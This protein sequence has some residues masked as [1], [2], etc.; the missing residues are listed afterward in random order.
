MRFSLAFLLKTYEV[1]TSQSDPEPT[2]I[3]D[4][5]GWEPIS[6]FYRLWASLINEDMRHRSAS[7]ALQAASIDPICSDDD[8]KDIFK[9]RR[10]DRWIDDLK[11]TDLVAK[12]YELCEKYMGDDY[13]RRLSVMDLL[14][15]T[16]FRTRFDEYFKRQIRQL[17]S[18]SCQIKPTI[19]TSYGHAERHHITVDTKDSSGTR[20]T[21]LIVEKLAEEKLINLPEGGSAKSFCES[22][23]NE[24]TVISGMCPIDG[25]PKPFPSVSGDEYTKGFISAIRELYNPLIQEDCVLSRSV[26]QIFKDAQRL[27]GA[28]LAQRIAAEEFRSSAV[29]SRGKAAE[30]EVEKFIEIKRGENEWR[31][32]DLATSQFNYEYQ[33]IWDVCTEASAVYSFVGRGLK[34]NEFNG[35]G[36]QIPGDDQSWKRFNYTSD[37][38]PKP[39]EYYQ[40]ITDDCAYLM[41]LMRVP[42]TIDSPIAK[43]PTK[44]EMYNMIATFVEDVNDMPLGSPDALDHY[45]EYVWRYLTEGIHRKYWQTDEGEFSRSIQIDCMACSGSATL[46][47]FITAS[48]LSHGFGDDVNIQRLPLLWKFILANGHTGLMAY[49]VSCYKHFKV[50]AKDDQSFVISLQDCT[51]KISEH[52]DFETVLND[53]NII[54]NEP[55][56]IGQLSFKAFIAAM[57]NLALHLTPIELGF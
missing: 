34:S 53:A 44:S 39:F 2:N 9:C 26:R 32:D 20:P 1:F 18:N 45:Y 8:M 55:E 7:V 24:D 4:L 10:G 43:Y 22:L 12:A 17:S 25:F 21:Y 54:L 51:G 46:S 37:R 48:G 30:Q 27:P 19:S 14:S 38:S 41:L 57:E 5:I 31:L 23:E 13:D 11:Y 42:P 35:R 29:V 36:R 47:L 28:I 50:I 33:T 40:A 56:W 49:F 16:S 6:P 15:E 52:E 3:A